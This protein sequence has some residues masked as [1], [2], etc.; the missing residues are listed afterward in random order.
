MVTVACVLRSGGVYTPDWVAKLQAGVARSLSAP[1]RFVCLSDI[2]VP[3]ERIALELPVKNVGKLEKSNDWHV[4]SGWWH[5]IELFKKGRFTGPTIYFDL[6]T[7]FIGNIDFLTVF[8]KFYA[9][10]DPYN[11]GRLNSSVMTWAG[12]YS[13][14]YD[15][16]CTAPEAIQH[17]YDKVEP[18]KNRR[19]GDQAFIEDVL[20]SYGVDFSLINTTRGRV[21]SYKASNLQCDKPDDASVILFHGK[22]KMHDLLHTWVGEEWR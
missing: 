20:L 15:E 11:L 13:F 3:C 5:K 8:D 21:K 1:H 14:I 10:S 16:F 6:D 22:P 4:S 19:I 7:L 2:E 9:T 18:A 12:D 17:H